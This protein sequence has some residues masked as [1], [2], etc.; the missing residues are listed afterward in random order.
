MSNNKRKSTEPK[1]S[2]VFVFH[3]ANVNKITC[4]P[5]HPR[6]P[7]VV[8]PEGRARSNPWRPPGVGPKQ[9]IN[10]G[11]LSHRGMYNVHIKQV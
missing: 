3:T 7:P 10:S 1:M 11:L 6:A 4:I 5:Y 9:A 2:R 8:T